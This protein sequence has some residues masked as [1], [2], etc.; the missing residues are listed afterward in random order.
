[1]ASTSTLL[2]SLPKEKYLGP[3]LNYYDELLKLKGGNH[4]QSFMCYLNAEVIPGAL[5]SNVSATLA[6]R[7]DDMLIE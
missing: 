7:L 6:H 1:M 2:Q 3:E 5:M 4:V